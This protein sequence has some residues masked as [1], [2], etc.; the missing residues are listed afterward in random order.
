MNE[1]ACLVFYINLFKLL[2][3]EKWI[4]FATAY[5]RN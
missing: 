4:R 3:K 5:L 2:N 1:L